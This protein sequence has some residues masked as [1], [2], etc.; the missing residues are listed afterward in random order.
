MAPYGR[1]CT[2]HIIDSDGIIIESELNAKNSLSRVDFVGAY[3]ADI[4]DPRDSHHYTNALFRAFEKGGEVST[5]RVRG[6][7][8]IAKFERNSTHRVRQKMWNIEGIKDIE[9]VLNVMGV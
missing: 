4:V 9:T 5:F 8:Y 7:L 6:Q 3:G 1:K 2:T